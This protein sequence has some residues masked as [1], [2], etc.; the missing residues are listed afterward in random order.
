MS[1]QVLKCDQCE[2]LAHNMSM[3][4]FTCNW[5]FGDGRKCTGTLVQSVLERVLDPRL[6]CNECGRRADNMAIKDT[7]CN[8]RFSNGDHCEGTLEA[9]DV[10]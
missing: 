6:E 9:V 1:V 10:E 5:R 4:N 3:E 2:R 7:T 8:W